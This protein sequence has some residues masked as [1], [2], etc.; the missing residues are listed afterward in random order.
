MKITFYVSPKKLLMKLGME[1]KVPQLFSL[2]MHFQKL[3]S[4]YLANLFS[5]PI[6]KTCNILCQKR[7]IFLKDKKDKKTK[8]TYLFFL[9]INIQYLTMRAVLNALLTNFGMVEIGKMTFF[10][11]SYVISYMI[12][13]TL[14]HQEKVLIII[15]L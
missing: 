11:I 7:S 8:A 14:Y 9:S 12:H 10:V 3:I 5:R 6:F 1:M 15:T 2:L 13:M 4:F